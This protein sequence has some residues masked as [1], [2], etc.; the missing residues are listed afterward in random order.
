MYKIPIKVKIA[1]IKLGKD[2][3]D[4]RIRRRIKMS[5]Q[6]ERAGISRTTLGKIEKGDPGVS[7]ACYALV[8][9]AMGMENR[10]RE[11]VDANTDIT[12]RTLEEESLPQRVRFKKR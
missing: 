3:K 7:I 4:A 6:S 5:I 9:F 1:L 12:G 10:L 11:I 8:M 2:L